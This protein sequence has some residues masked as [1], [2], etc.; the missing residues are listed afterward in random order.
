MHE[1]PTPPA[2]SFPASLAER[3]SRL[4]GRL[5]DRATPT[6][7]MHSVREL[8]DELLT[9]DLS[10][11]SARERQIDERAIRIV[12]E[13]VG[14]LQAIRA[15]PVWSQPLQAAAHRA[16]R[17]WRLV[18]LVAV[19]LVVGV[20]LATLL[21]GAIQRGAAAGD[22]AFAIGLVLVAVLVILQVL[23]AYQML[24]RPSSARPAADSRPE[25][26]LS[27]DSQGVLTTLTES[28]L[29]VDQLEQAIA[30]PAESATATTASLADYPELLRAIQQVYAA[31][32][33]N[34]PQR[35]R[36]RAEGLRASL[37]QYGIELLDEWARDWPPPPELFTAQRSLD[38]TSTE[39]RVILPAVVAGDEVIVPGRIAIPVDEDDAA[40]ARS[41]RATDADERSE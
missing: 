32:R 4:V 37:E 9:I 22:A 6:E 35:A 21:F 14:F 3:R 39:H 16:V 38:P 23:T 36:Q 34:D 7:A 13:S 41:G 8:L 5:A 19:Q 15:T 30:A 33:S 17:P 40:S 18:G 20:A 11:R 1:P 2:L 25:I 31:R 12:R 10:Q 28:L 29:A 24:A 27:V 26:A